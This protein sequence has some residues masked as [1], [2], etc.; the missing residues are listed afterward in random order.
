VHLPTEAQWEYTCRAGSKT[1]FSY[2]HDNDYGNVGDHSWNIENSDGRPHPVGQKKPNDWGLFD[3]HGNVWEWCSDW[4]QESYTNAKDKDPQ[5]PA[6]GTSRV[7]RGG[8]WRSPPSS[9]RSAVR[10]G[11]SPGDRFNNLG[12]RVSVD[13]K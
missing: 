4:W 9:C 11:C 2:G 7:L 8:C 6:N 1:R 10:S 13:S 12:F 5:G 3:M